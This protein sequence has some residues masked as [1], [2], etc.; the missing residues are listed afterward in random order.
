[1]ER[2]VHAVLGPLGVEEKIS[3]SLADCL[4]KVEDELIETPA[5]SSSKGKSNG[6]A[7]GGGIEAAGG[8][9]WS[10][11]VGLT[12]FLLKFGEGLGE[13]TGVARAFAHLKV[14]ADSLCLED[15]PTRRLYISAFT[16][17]AGYFFGGLIPLIPYFFLKQVHTALMYSCIVTGIILLIFGAVKTHYT[18]ATGGWKGYL[19]GAVSML[20]VGGG[21]AA[22]AFGIVRA[23]E[24]TDV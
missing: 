14:E 3:V 2:E 24:T 1:M 9:T 19:W 8:L 12:A 21:A 23:L 4:R 22:A 13:Y 10:D 18:G 17:G 11:D 7:N 16:I 6:H 20:A 15:V 5:V